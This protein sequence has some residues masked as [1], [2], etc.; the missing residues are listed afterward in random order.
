MAGRAPDAHT[1]GSGP[2]R[3]PERAWQVI[4]GTTMAPP[5]NV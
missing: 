3:V 1:M 5:G 2:R 4:A